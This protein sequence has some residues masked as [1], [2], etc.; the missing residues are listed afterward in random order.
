MVNETLV[1]LSEETSVPLVPGRGK[2]GSS[3]S[4]TTRYSAEASLINAGWVLTAAHCVYG[5][6]RGQNVDSSG[7]VVPRK[8]VKVIL[9]EFD[10]RNIDGYEVHKS[11][12]YHL[13]R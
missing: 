7:C 13:E 3:S 6:I 9:G 5:L 2:L 10:A 1:T 4:I 12:C 8:G 11:K